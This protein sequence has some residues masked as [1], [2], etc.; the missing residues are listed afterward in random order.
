MKQSRNS[1]PSDDLLKD[2]VGIVDPKILMF[3][4]N[5]DFKT[6][7]KKSMQSVDVYLSKHEDKRVVAD[8]DKMNDMIEEELQ[9]LDDDLLSPQ[10]SFYDKVRRASDLVKHSD[11]EGA[12]TVYKECLQEFRSLSKPEDSLLPSDIK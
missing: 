3:D 5:V 10:S 9:K 6:N 1:I 11:Y 2:I 12:L 4:D 7:L 8:V